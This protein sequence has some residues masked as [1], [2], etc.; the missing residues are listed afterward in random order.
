MKI[1]KNINKFIAQNAS[2][3]LSA[4]AVLWQVL[5]LYVPLFL[6]VYTSLKRVTD[7]TGFGLTLDNYRAVLRSPYFYIIARSGFIALGVT[8]LCLFCAY[9]VAYYLAL[10][11]DKRWKNVLL[12]LLTLPFWT[13]FLIQ[14]Y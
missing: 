7:T 11:V 5:F 4:P 12:F 1:K 10:K 2:F 9:P 13:N 6:V 3:M 14:I 8:L